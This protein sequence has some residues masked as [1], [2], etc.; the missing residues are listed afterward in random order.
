[1]PAGNVSS[2]V[3][4]LKCDGFAQIRITLQTWHSSPNKQTPGLKAIRCDGATSYD[5]RFL[6]LSYFK[7]TGVEDV[8][9][10]GPVRPSQTSGD[11]GIVAPINCVLI[12]DRLRLRTIGYSTWGKK[13]ASKTV[14][15]RREGGRSPSLHAPLASATAILLAE[16]NLK[17]THPSSLR[18]V[19]IPLHP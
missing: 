13:Q 16:L 8:V 11:W 6:R 15:P 2:P 10:N 19:P 5:E 3:G 4:F 17:L 7:S 1:M 14:T 18:P 12:L 9:R